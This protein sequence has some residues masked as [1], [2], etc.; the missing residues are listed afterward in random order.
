ML[1][2]REHRASESVSAK[3]EKKRIENRELLYK[4][5]LETDTYAVS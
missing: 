3:K 5:L 2:R 1:R 4:H